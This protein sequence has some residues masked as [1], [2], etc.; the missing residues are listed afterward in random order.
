MRTSVIVTLVTLGLGLVACTD[1]AGSEVSNELIH[2]TYA[3][4]SHGARER[5]QAIQHGA[6]AG[7]I[8][9]DGGDF[10]HTVAAPG[11]VTQ[12]LLGLTVGEQLTGQYLQ[13][14]GTGAAQTVVATLLRSEGDGT[15]TVIGAIDVVD[16]PN[17]WATYGGAL[18]TP[19]P[20]ESG[21][22]YYWYVNVPLA[23][24]FIGQQGYTVLP[25][26]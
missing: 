15:D 21:K 8:N 19:V 12:G 1:T 16:P 2:I 5:W 14:K 7:N 24:T 4:S 11:F 13:I 20:V 23:G 18:A 25:A 26:P 6:T 10:M 22:S 17:S 3:P 9:Y